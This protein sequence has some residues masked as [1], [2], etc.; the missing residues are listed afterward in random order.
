MSVVARR[1]DRPVKCGLNVSN[2]TVI[3]AKLPTGAG[4]K[5]VGPKDG[6][7][8]SAHNLSAPSAQHSFALPAE[9]DT[10]T[11]HSGST[12]EHGIQ[13]TGRPAFAIINPG[14]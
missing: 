4:Q 12:L 13:V 6:A 11:I 3:G 8:F 10:M 1:I 5:N 2:S 14:T 9:L 7:Y